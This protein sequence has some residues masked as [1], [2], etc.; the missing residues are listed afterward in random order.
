M[1]EAIR[2][3]AGV[4]LLDHPSDR[5]TT[6]RSRWWA[7]PAAPS[8]P[9]LALA[10]ARGGRHRSAGTHRAEH[11][12]LGAVDAVPFVPIEGV[13]MAE[14]VRRQKGGA[15]GRALRVPVYLYEEASREPGPQE[16]GRHPPRRIR[17]AGREDGHR[18]WARRTSALRRRT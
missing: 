1:A 16:P 11:P 6:D 12:R 15:E 8:A 14:R 5:R 9:C 2:A 3:V 13:T 7:T 17:G 18:G 4:R 10:G